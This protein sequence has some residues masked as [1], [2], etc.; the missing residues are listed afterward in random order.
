[1]RNTF[2]EELKQ[3]NRQMISTGACCESAI[4]TAIDYLRTADPEKKDDVTDLVEQIS[5]REREIENLCLKILMQQQPVAR[6]LRTVSSA[7]KMVS[8]LERI[9]DNADDIAEIVSKHHIPVGHEIPNLQVMSGK[10]VEMLGFAIDAFVKQ[11]ERL[12]RKVIASDDMVDE[13]FNKVK[14]SLIRLPFEDSEEALDTILDLFMV[15]K[16]FERIA[17]HTVNIARWVVFMTSGV[18]EGNTN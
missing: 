10:V 14:H 15:A 7:L 4:R 1:M 17:D 6:D 18:L 13:T 11:D 12:A 3:L 9:G 5:H 16:Y 2:E 8:D